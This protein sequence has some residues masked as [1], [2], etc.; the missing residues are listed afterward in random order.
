MARRVNGSANGHQAASERTREE[1]LAAGLELLL[2]VP[3]STAFGHLTATKI[4]S[5]AGRTTGAFFHQ[6]ATLDAYLDDFARYVLRPELAA[7]L[8]KT[9]DRLGERLQRGETFAAALTAAAQGVP[10]QTSSDPQMVIELLMCNRAL[11]DPEFRARVSPLYGD[12]DHAAARVYEGLMELLNR[13]PRPPFTARTIGAMLTAVAQGLSIRTS[14][15]PGIYPPEIFGWTVLSL[16][17]MMTRRVGDTDDVTEY[18]ERLS[19]DP[20]GLP[21]AERT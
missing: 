14:L 8:Q 17:P 13:E 2:T 21:A 4:A 6:W 10:E 11:H 20:P 12:L 15:T 1:M 3:A 7:N 9:L 5:A 18:S 16:I 19:L